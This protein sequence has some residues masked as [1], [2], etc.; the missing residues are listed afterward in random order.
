MKINEI[1]RT[2]RLAKHLTQEQLAGLL[3]VTAPAVHKW[4]K[5]ISY[6][7]I[8]L[9]PPLARL[10]DT[11]LNTLLSFQENLSEREVALFLNHLSELLDAQGFEATYQAAAEKLREFPT[12]SPL[13]LQT[14]LFLD[15]A[16]TMHPTLPR[17]AEY[18][19]TIEELYRRAADSEDSNIRNQAISILISHCMERKE[20]TQAQEMLDTLPDVSPVDKKQLQVNLYIALGRLDEAAKLEEERLLSSTNELHTI[21]M[22]LMEVALKEERFEDAEYIANVS[23]QGA[24]LFDL[25][26]YSS[27]AA[28]FQ[29]YSAQKKRIQL[30]K[31]LLPMLKSLTK[32]WDLNA[33]PLY[34]H[35]KSKPVEQNFGPK[36]QKTL[37]HAIRT[38]PETEFLRDDPDFQSLE[39][40]LTE[41]R[42][43]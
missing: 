22:T 6:P 25:W 37:L 29:L 32:K 2:R 3:G 35:I 9:L 31:T 41:T 27:Y 33:S 14:A 30:L 26:E 12:C 43:S 4:E 17:S 24:K 36:M 1:I 34:R 28:H 7:D 8:T 19:S 18:K 20:Y 5:G 15:G 13:I 16:L 21:L 10:L 38:D 40:E 39:Q 23:R 42:N 11:D